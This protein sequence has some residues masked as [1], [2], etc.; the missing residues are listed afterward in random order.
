MPGFVSVD[1]FASVNNEDKF[2]SLS[3]EESEEAV[4]DRAKDV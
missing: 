1:H 4:T 3:F 2:I